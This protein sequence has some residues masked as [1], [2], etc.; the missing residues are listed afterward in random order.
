[1]IFNDHLWK[2]LEYSAELSPF[3]Y[4]W[5]NS[6]QKSRL[7]KELFPLMYCKQIQENNEWEL[8]LFMY[9]N[10]K[11]GNMNIVY[12]PWTHLMIFH[13]KPTLADLWKSNLFCTLCRS[14]KN[15]TTDLQKPTNTFL[16]LFKVVVTKNGITYLYVL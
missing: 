1:M 16:T 5:E 3:V 14:I 9:Q 10:L 13:T 8:P 6:E 12:L 11:K 15:A 2:N 4:V 7:H